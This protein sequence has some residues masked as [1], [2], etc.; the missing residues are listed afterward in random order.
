MRFGMTSDK[1]PGV[2]VSVGGDEGFVDALLRRALAA[3]EIAEALH[4]HAAAQHIRKPCN[5][6]AVAVGIL[7]RL[8]KVLETSRAKFVFSVC[9]AGSS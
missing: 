5:G 3:D 8:C 9:L 1:S 7:E 4:H 2:A 6:L